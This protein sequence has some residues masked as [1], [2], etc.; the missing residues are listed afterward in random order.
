MFAP[1][2]RWSS[3]PP[4][5]AQEFVLCCAHC[6]FDHVLTMWKVPSCCLGTLQQYVT[7]LPTLTD[8][9]AEKQQVGRQALQP[10]AAALKCN[11]LLRC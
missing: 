5:C 8:R 7:P 3:N 10:G 6:G 4:V 9:A 2:C 1:P 11:T